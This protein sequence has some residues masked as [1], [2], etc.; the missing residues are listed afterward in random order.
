MKA[1]EQLRNWEKSIHLQNKLQKRNT[2]ALQKLR[3]IEKDIHISNLKIRKEKLWNNAMDIISRGNGWENC[4]RFD[5]LKRY[6]IET[7]KYDSKGTELSSI[8]INNP[9][10]RF[11]IISNIP[12]K[13]Q[14][15]TINLTNGT[16]IDSLLSEKFS[17]NHLYELV[18][19]Y[20]L[21]FKD[22]IVDLGMSFNKIVGEPT[23]NDHQ[24]YAWFTI[25]PKPFPLI[26]TEISIE[27]PVAEVPINNSVGLHKRKAFPEEM[28]GPIAGNRPLK[29][30]SPI[31]EEDYS[32]EEIEDEKDEEDE[33]DICPIISTFIVMLM[34]IVLFIWVN[35][36]VKV[37]I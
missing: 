32:S 8:L 14:L 21:Y 37:V 13:E 23:N 36:K 3:E 22:N 18:E 16:S 29:I 11:D 24:D 34:L 31:V 35:L 12:I 1:I 6:P 9:R 2:L 5:H 30:R 15:Q 25:Q 26:Q 7:K 33:S 19:N 28:L 27:N 20:D 4:E 17:T 10:M